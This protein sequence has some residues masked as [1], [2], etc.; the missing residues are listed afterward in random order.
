MIKRSGEPADKTD[1]TGLVLLGRIN[2]AQGLRGE[3]RVTSF[4]ENPE[5]IATYGPLTDQNGRSFTI[6]A[7]RVIKGSVLAARLAGVGDRPS[8]EALKGVELYVKKSRLPV[9]DENEWYHDDLLGLRADGE[10]G[11]EIGEV[12]AIQ[13]YGAGDLLEIRLKGSRQTA[14]VPFTETAVPKI[15][16]KAGRIVVILPEFEDPSD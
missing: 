4:T 3:V 9:A 2:A 11:V 1:G 5:N 10:D 6:E 13:N 15:E 12:V 16:V 14:L 8:A 7:V